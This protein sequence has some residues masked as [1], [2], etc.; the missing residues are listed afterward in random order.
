MAS[1]RGRVVGCMLA[2]TGSKKGGRD[3]KGHSVLSRLNGL[4][5]GVLKVEQQQRLLPP[6]SSHAFHSTNW[7]TGKEK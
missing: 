2:E 4:T 3:R 5:N 6:C 7:T 1:M